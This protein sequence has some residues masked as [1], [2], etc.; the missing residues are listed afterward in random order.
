MVLKNSMVLSALALGCIAYS[1]PSQ[2]M[3]WQDALTQAERHASELSEKQHALA[4]AR[5][6]SI[7]AGELPDPQLVTGVDN[8]PVQGG[9]AW[10]TT[11]DF[12]TMQRIGVMQSVTN[13]DK[14]IATH[15]LAEAAVERSNRELELARLNALAGVATEFGVIMLLYLRHALELRS[16]NDSFSRHQLLES[17]QEGAVLRV[18]SKAMT[19]AVILAG[20]MPILLGGGTGSEII[21]RIAA[22]MVGGM[23]TAPLLSL[24]IIPVGYGLLRNRQIKK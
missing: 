23:L 9:E 18:R 8:L 14:R 19:V 11:R 7:S 5:S 21:S 1:S 15:R 16:Q 20:L 4:A 17:I 13:A 6:E 3:G 2:S 12:M 10:S 22:P 24:F